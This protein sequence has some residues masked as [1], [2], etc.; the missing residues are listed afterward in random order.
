MGSIY[1]D[2]PHC[3]E[4]IHQDCVR[5][6]PDSYTTII[7]TCPICNALSYREEIHEKHCILSAKQLNNMASSIAW[8]I[9]KM[10]PKERNTYLY[11]IGNT[12]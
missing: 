5:Q 6:E 8:H 10:T 3:D 12:K 11:L 4:D 2:C 1:T 9:E 7:C